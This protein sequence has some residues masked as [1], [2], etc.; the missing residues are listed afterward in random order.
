MDNK[1]MDYLNGVTVQQYKSDI[2]FKTLVESV[3]D[4]MYIIPK[5]QRKYRWNR[6]QVVSLVESLLRGLPIPPI[7]TCRNA[8]N[9][10]E[11]LDGQQR[12]MSLFFYYIGYFLNRKK[13]SA[14]NFSEI[15][16]NEGT[17][18]DALINQFQVEK[19]H[20]NLKDSNGQEVNVDYASLPIE[21]KRK[22]DYTTI[23]VIEIKIGRE[24]RREEVL[25]AIFANLNKNGS[26]LSRQEQ[27]NGI[28]MCEF[29][30]MLHE[31]NKKNL[32]WR[33]LWGREHAKDRDFETLLR[34]CA[35]K[36]KVNLEKNKNSI[37]QFEIRGYYSSYAEM[38]DRFSKEAISFTKAEISEYKNS[39]ER[40][41]ELFD[42]NGVLSSKVALMEGF[43]IVFEKL[44]IKKVIS[45]KVIEQVQNSNGY[46]NNSGQRTVNIKKM[47]GRWRAVYEVWNGLS[48]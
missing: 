43:Y 27:R 1:L 47:N 11:I 3:N 41:V 22:V 12:V 9:Q 33:K 24:D 48:E 15:E 5:Y 16:V 21:I 40:F 37:P 25:Q 14:I 13:E 7:Y 34:L 10:L 36:K 26:I 39:L 30:D 4:N 46:K 38:L 17:F 18:A 35:L 8:N 19:L 2:G 28:Y 44:G 20:V 42:I 32:K 29:Y 23:T 45:K 6:E 31:F